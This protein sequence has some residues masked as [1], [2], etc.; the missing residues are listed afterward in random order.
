[1][2]IEKN[3]QTERDRHRQ[4]VTFNRLRL[5]D[6]NIYRPTLEQAFPGSEAIFLPNAAPPSPTQRIFILCPSC[7]FIS[8]SNRIIEV[9]CDVA[10]IKPVHSVIG[11]MARR[12]KH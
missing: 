7:I 1:M 10:V 12:R 3:R 11:A 2:L 8:S 6:R 4:T 5:T 9:I